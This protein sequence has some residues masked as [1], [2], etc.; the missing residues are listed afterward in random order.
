MNY[1]INVDFETY[2]NALNRFEY[3]SNAT[4]DIAD[5]L[6]LKQFDKGKLTGRCFTFNI[7]EVKKV[8]DTYIYKLD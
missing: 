5:S 8:K 6:T 4:Y 3:I 1:T 7:V 2:N